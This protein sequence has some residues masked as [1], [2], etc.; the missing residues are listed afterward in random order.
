M[1]KEKTTKEL[2]LQDVFKKEF[3]D[4]EK[5]LSFESGV[6]LLEELVAQV[7]SGEL[8]L[9]QSITAYTKGAELLEHLKVLL[10]NAESKLEMVKVNG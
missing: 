3:K 7:E 10:G 1:P 4:I 2:T 8:P 5:S 6:R 9:E